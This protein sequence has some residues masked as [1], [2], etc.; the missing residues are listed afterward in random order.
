VRTSI[1]WI[2]FSFNFVIKHHQEETMENSTSLNSSSLILQYSLIVPEYVNFPF[3][4]VTIFGM[5]QGI[6]IRHPLYAVLFL[7]LIVAFAT[8]VTHIVSFT[9]LHID[10]FVIVSNLLNSQSLYFYCTSWCVT[11][12]I[13][14]V[15]IFHE[16]WIHNLIPSSNVKCILGPMS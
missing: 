10:K 13:R 3:L 11:S 6:E 16:E 9:V 7:N 4:L 1:I 15:Y 12:V 14:Y 2:L 5:Y 8:T